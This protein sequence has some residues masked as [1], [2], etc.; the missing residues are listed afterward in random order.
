MGQGR[1]A[2]GVAKSN[3][4]SAGA[5]IDHGAG[6]VRSLIQ[7]RVSV[8]EKRKLQDIAA[9]NQQ[10]LSDFLRE[11]LNEII[12]DCHDGAAILKLRKKNRE[13]RVIQP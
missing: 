11:A 1:C 2:G 12:A 10:S 5:H 4:E 3:V 8:P 6:G 13:N 7:I 9:L